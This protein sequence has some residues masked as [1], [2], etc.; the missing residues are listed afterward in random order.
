MN[1][2]WLTVAIALAGTTSAHAQRYFP[3]PDDRPPPVYGPP[4]IYGP[5]MPLPSIEQVFGF[6]MSLPGVQKQLY[7][8]TVPPSHSQPQPYAP[9]PPMPAAS[10][11]ATGRIDPAARRR[12][13]AAGV[14]AETAQ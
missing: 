6:V 7:R 3:V 13:V 11:A 1:A 5:P 4:P 10:C 14:E 9:P 8:L 2:K 12:V